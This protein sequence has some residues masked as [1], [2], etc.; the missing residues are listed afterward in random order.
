MLLDLYFHHRAGGEYAR[1]AHQW[2]ADKNKAER[3][4]QLRED[5]E[6]LMV[7]IQQFVIGGSICQY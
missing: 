5:D 2:A 1:R 4:R 7:I 6:A 3:E